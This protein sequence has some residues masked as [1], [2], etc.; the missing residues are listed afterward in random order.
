MYTSLFTHILT[1]IGTEKQNLQTEGINRKVST[2]HTH[3]LSFIS[4]CM[5]SYIHTYILYIQTVIYT[6]RTYFIGTEKQNFKMERI[7]RQ[8][9]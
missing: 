8:V 2:S 9:R 7:R 1:N 3:L 5:S 6:Y 4:T